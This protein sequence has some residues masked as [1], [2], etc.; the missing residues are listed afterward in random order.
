M[1]LHKLNWCDNKTCTRGDIENSMLHLK[2]DSAGHAART[3]RG[4]KESQN[5]HNTEVE[6]SG[7]HRGRSE[8]G[9]RY[10]QRKAKSDLSLH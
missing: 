10:W 4:W 8:M 7:G 2:R 6:T 3:V 9:R 5:R 1:N